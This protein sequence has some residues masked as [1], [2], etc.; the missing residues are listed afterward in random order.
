MWDIYGNIVPRTN[1]VTASR[2]FA[3]AAP[4][5]W[6]SLPVNITASANYCTF[7]TQLKTH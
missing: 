2:V 7:K 3:V 6:N 1:T 5:I 4:R